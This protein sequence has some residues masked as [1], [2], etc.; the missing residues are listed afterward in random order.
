MSKPLTNAR[1]T[2]GVTIQTTNEFTTANIDTLTTSSLNVSENIALDG[3]LEA[4]NL[5]VRESEIAEVKISENIITI[6]DGSIFNTLKL[7]A[8]NISL[9]GNVT[10]LNTSTLSFTNIMTKELLIR[11]PVTQIASQ[12]ADSISDRG[13]ILN[14]IDNEQQMKG[15]MGISNEDK[16]FRIIK[17]TSYTPD[18]TTNTN[19][20]Y[21]SSNRDF[22]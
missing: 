8:D 12:S 1:A 10:I 2:S 19:S 9:E 17:N 13:L 18:D 21:N 11:D 5:V 14:Y 22:I 6:K 15:F 16:I 7:I 4:S 3:D 20:F